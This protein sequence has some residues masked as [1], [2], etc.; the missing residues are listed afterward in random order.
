MYCTGYDIKLLRQFPQFIQD[1]SFLEELETVDEEFEHSQT[2]AREKI[3][4]SKTKFNQEAVPMVLSRYH[5]RIY[6]VISFQG[7]CK[8]QEI[9]PRND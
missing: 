7:I 6:Y 9:N 3:K 1:Y 5:N 4:H 2:Q 8:I